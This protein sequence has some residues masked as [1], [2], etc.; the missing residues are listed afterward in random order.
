MMTLDRFFDS[1]ER[2]IPGWLSDTLVTVGIVLPLL[3]IF[4]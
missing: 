4:F 1:Y 2:L 3:I